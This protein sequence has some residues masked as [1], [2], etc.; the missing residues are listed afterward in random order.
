MPT[1]LDC[2][3]FRDLFGSARM[4]EAFDTRSM[5][6]AWLTAEAAL[7][8]AQAE[9]GVIPSR[10]G[11]AD[12]A[13]GRRQALRHGRATAR[14]R[15]LAAPARARRPRARGALRRARGTRPLGGDHPGHHGHRHGPADPGCAPVGDRPGPRRPRAVPAARA[16]VRGVTDAG[17]NARSAG[18]A[19]DI[20]PEGGRMG[21]RADPRS[22]SPA[23]RAGDDL[24]GTTWRWGRHTGQSRR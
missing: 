23:R 7:A 12:R 4:R 6:Q 16:R 24:G 11:R 20:R 18:G 5:A 17:A 13:Q 1:T 8:A 14:D 19:D 22:R 2:E 21:G 15:A 10:R 9:V 3:L